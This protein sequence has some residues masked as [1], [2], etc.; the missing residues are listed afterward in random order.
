MLRGFLY[1]GSY[2][3]PAGRAE[4]LEALRNLDLS[5]GQQYEYDHLYECLSIL[6]HKATALLG[7]DAILVA[8][9]T[10]ALSVA[11]PTASAGSVVLFT[12]LLASGISSTLLLFVIALFWSETP[13]FAS[14]HDHL[15]RLLR[16]R[17]R[18]SVYYRCAWLS[19]MLALGL[20]IVA[21]AAWTLF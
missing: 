10:I 12:S 14:A 21:I 2:G 8:A 18:R 15:D 5:E 17:G 11:H 4:Y 13:E 16:V 20:I 7:F 1:Q 3:T 19:A 6:D 9:S